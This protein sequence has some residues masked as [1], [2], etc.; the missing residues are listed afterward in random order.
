MYAII[1]LGKG[2]YYTSVVFGYYCSI[3]ATDDYQRYR[4]SI[5][6]QYYLVLNK[7]KNRLCRHYVFDSNS[8]YLD[9]LVLIVDTDNSDWIVDEKSHGCVDYLSDIPADKI[10]DELSQE[11]L[12][13]CIRAD[14]EYVYNEY[15]EIHTK[16]DIDNL[17]AVAGWFHDGYIEKCEKVSDDELYVL[18]Y[19][20]WGC[21]IEMWFSG[22]VS[23][24]IDSR[25]SCDEYWW[26]DSTMLI[27]NGYIYFTDGSDMSISEIKDDYCW[28]K[29]KNVKYHI[30]PKE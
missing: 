25:S 28:F 29:A 13:R 10:E 24:C 22:D 6:N 11:Q 2:E 12:Q 19:D 7:E 3:T 15:P 17:M 23:Y 9:P 27:E 5:H 18:F 21:K 8:K 26:N 14:S 16:K 20:I 30:I 4:Q 1:R